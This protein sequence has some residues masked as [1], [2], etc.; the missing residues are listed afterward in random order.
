MRH[1]RTGA[2]GLDSARKD[3]GQHPEGKAEPAERDS[4]RSRDVER[5]K[6]QANEGE[7][8]QDQGEHLTPQRI[9]CNSLWYRNPEVT[10]AALWC[11]ADPNSFVKR[12]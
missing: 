5:G 10:D 3:H 11:R 8:K 4:G 7:H 12:R 9:G 6:Q 1:V 2:E